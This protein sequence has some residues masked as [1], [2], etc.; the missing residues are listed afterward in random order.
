MPRFEVIVRGITNYTLTVKAPDEFDAND[1]AIAELSRWNDIPGCETISCY[2][3]SSEY[4][5]TSTGWLGD[6]DDEEDEQDV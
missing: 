6:D 4:E 3:D 1:Q 2:D 5:V